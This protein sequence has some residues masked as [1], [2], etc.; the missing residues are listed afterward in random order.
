M[1]NLTI[2]GTEV[3]KTQEER[4]LEVLKGRCGGWVLGKAKFDREMGISQF[5]RAIHNLRHNRHK[6]PSY[7]GK[8]ESKFLDGDQF[9][10]YRI[11]PAGQQKL[12]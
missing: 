7:E 1:N 4:I 2:G 5:P 12:V 11:A 8:I 6:Y 9:M 10:S 3:E